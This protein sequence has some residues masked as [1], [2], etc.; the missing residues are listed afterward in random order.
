[1]RP[2]RRSRCMRAGRALLGVLC[3]VLL[4]VACGGAAGKPVPPP[5]SMSAREVTAR[6]YAAL[7][8]GDRA[9]AH[10]CLDPAYDRFLSSAP[11]S[12]FTNLDSLGD[13][14]VGD[15]RPAGQVGGSEAFAETAEVAVNYRATYKQTIT[16]PNG[17]QTRFV[18][19]GRHG[20]DQPWLIFG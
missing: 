16:V 14:Q 19:L 1:A 20:R 15:P 8:K 18:V 7:E 10:G 3:V 13:V 11:D 2:G 17:R 6:Y 5:A 4:A 12:D 9:T